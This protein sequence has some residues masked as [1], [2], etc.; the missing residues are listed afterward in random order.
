MG[1]HASA[2][3]LL[4]LFDGVVERVDDALVDIGL[5]LDVVA[6]VLALLG[7]QGVA[8]PIVAEFD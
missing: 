1:V 8:H 6:Y 2:F 4:P 5:I 7:N 3:V